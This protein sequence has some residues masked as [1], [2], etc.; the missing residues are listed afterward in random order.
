M[1]IS[2]VPVT[3]GTTLQQT[4]NLTPATEGCAPSLASTVCTRTL[5]LAPGRYTTAIST[6]DA[7]G[8][9]GTVLS[10][11]QNLSVHIAA[12][13]ANQLQMT[14][15]GIPHAI[16]VSWLTPGVRG[17]Q[18]LGFT[19][20][21]NTAQKFDVIATD[22]DGAPIVGPGAPVFTTSICERI[23]LDRAD[24]RAEHPEYAERNARRSERRDGYA[25]LDGCV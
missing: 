2:F 17:S 15:N 25:P 16:L 19:I 7:I 11:G 13:A 14:L 20:F 9:G 23:R 22:A 21:G 24:A 4:I 18:G 10:S 6:Y 12:G 5:A 8:G 1:A 3:T